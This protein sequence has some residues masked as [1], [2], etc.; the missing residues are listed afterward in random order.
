MPEYRRWFQLGGTFFFTLVTEQR[1]PILCD[2]RARMLLRAS[3]EE[4]QQRWPFRAL[5]WVLLPDHLLTIWT[6]PVGDGD[7]SRRWAF[8]KKQF[9]RGWLANGGPEAARSASRVKNRRRGVWQRRFW[10]HLI[11]D[12][13]EFQRLLDYIHHNPI[14]HGYVRCAH[15]WPYS[16]FHRMVRE[17]RYATDWCCCCRRRPPRERFTTDLPL[18]DLVGE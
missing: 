17:G 1:A 9:T 18:T 15:E 8:L 11:R 12:E 3:I 4:T 10:E 13:D 5:A 2:Q 14:K 6:L 16:T 7:F